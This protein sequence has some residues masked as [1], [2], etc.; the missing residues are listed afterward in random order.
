M[1]GSFVGM[2]WLGEPNGKT[3]P[4]GRIWIFPSLRVF[5][6]KFE[7]EKVGNGFGGY[8]SL[9]LCVSSTI[10]S[11]RMASLIYDLSSEWKNHFLR[12]IRFL[13]PFFLL[14]N[15]LLSGASFGLL[16]IWKEV[17]KWCRWGKRIAQRCSRRETPPNSV[18]RMSI[19]RKREKKREKD[20][21]YQA[22]A[23][24]ECLILS[25]FARQVS[26]L[27]LDYCMSECNNE[28]AA[29]VHNGNVLERI[30]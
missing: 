20:H 5:W 19:D 27:S 29:V 14:G 15:A 22:S 4:P 3:H 17:R 1:G 28:N 7:N 26:F 21:F 8:F 25:V 11:C 13:V 10:L 2:S 30:C 23:A 18:C 9:S 6:S 24:H 16:S 12:Q